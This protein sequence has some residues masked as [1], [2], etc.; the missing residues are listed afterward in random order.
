MNKTSQEREILK[1]LGR[2]YK[3]TLNELTGQLFYQ[4]R[5]GRTKAKVFDRRY[6]LSLFTSD[7]FKYKT[8]IVRDCLNCIFYR[9]MNPV[10]AFFEESKYLNHTLN[11]FDELEGYFSLVGCHPIPFG[12]AL[13]DHLVRAIRCIKTEQPNRFVFAL[14]SANE[15]IGKTQFVE[16]LFPN[17]LRDYCMS[18]L[19]GSSEKRDTM[20]ASKFIVNID[21]FAGASNSANAKLKAMVSQ[22]SAALWVPFKN[23]IEQRPRIT[24]F[25]ATSNLRRNALL[26]SDSSNS[27]FLVYEVDAIDWSYKE[28]LDPQELWDY[29]LRLA[30][31]PSYIAEP[32][33]ETV[34]RVER[35]N[36][37][38]KVSRIKNKST[39]RKKSVRGVRV[40][41]EGV[42]LITAALMAFACSPWG[43]AMLGALLARLG[44][45]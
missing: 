13:Q 2:Y 10:K 41:K 32:N 9:Q 26:S 29:A 37:R 3:F 19:S 4:R 18:T 39:F 25:F 42:A 12:K 34:R 24:T 1:Y 11:P 8:S 16:W 33:I 45:A 36:M 31:D 6:F 5:D 30:N 40:S 7:R 15:Y 43:R 44:V 22:R 28:N 21:E 35:Y 23:C 14:V 17:E 38:Y 20:L 27:R